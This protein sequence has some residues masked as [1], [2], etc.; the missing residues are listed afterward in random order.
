VAVDSCSLYITLCISFTTPLVGLELAS[1]AFWVLKHSTLTRTDRNGCPSVCFAH[2]HFQ[3]WYWHVL[4]FSNSLSTSVNIASTAYGC[5]HILRLLTLV[6][7]H[8]HIYHLCQLSI[9]FILWH[10][11][12]SVNNRSS[13][14]IVRVTGAKWA[15]QRYPK[16]MAIFCEQVK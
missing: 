3:Q 11:L 7:L 5:I 6:I 4:T 12:N 13:T 1:S 8:N 10:L 15:S 2:C 14:W 16:S 9:F